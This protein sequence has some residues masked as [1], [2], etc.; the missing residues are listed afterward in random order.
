MIFH[1]Q[2]V[3]LHPGPEN[4]GY[5]GDSGTYRQPHN[6]KPPSPLY[7][8]VYCT[9]KSHISPLFLTLLPLCFTLKVLGSIKG[10]CSEQL[11]RTPD[12]NEETSRRGEEFDYSKVLSQKLNNP[13]HSQKAWSKKDTMLSVFLFNNNNKKGFKLD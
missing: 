10:A 1:S 9:H 13:V 2:P 8:A 3:C 12:R 5:H 6:A 7:P 11:F 4:P